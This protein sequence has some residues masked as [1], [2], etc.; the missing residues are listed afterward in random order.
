MIEYMNLAYL[1]L[2]VWHQLKV[3][4]AWHLGAA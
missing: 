1:H 4:W 2:G 3:R